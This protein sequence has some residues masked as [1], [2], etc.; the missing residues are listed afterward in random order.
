LTTETKYLIRL[1]NR[2][3]VSSYSVIL[4]MIPTRLSEVS[5]QIEWMKKNGCT[6]Q[7]DM[8]LKEQVDSVEEQDA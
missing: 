3:G 5:Q 4:N 8:L 6:Q 2:S 7:A 1:T